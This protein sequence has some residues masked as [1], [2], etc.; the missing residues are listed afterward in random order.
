MCLAYAL[1]KLAS[2]GDDMDEHE[3]AEC[4]ADIER[5]IY[6]ILSNGVGCGPFDGG[7]VLIAL[8]LQQTVGGDV[9]VLTRAH[10]GI[11][12][13]AALSV[14]GMLWD[15]DGPLPPSAF[16]ERFERSELSVLGHQ[17]GGYRLFEAG[18]LE[19]APRDEQVVDQLSEIFQTIMP[20][21]ASKP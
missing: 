15:F 14:N 12:D 9:V 16:I 2:K 19:D 13:H 8:A 18:D 20:R 6:D 4:R 11:A 17:C 1:N 5:D 3:W 21:I 10:S 7:C